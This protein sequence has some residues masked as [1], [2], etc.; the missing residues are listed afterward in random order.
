MRQHRRNLLNWCL[1]KLTRFS[2]HRSWVGPRDLENKLL[3]K[4][5]QTGRFMNATFEDWTRQ[6]NLLPREYFVFEEGIP[7]MIEAFRTEHRLEITM[8]DLNLRV[9][10]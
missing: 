5:H 4:L 7:R 3:A 2:L 9:K 10:N 6:L 8:Q 1:G